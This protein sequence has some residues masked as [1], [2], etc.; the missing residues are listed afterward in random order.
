MASQ[1]WTPERLA[2][3]RNLW[4]EGETAAAIAV[5]LGGLSRS[6]VLGKVYRLRLD[7]AGSTAAAKPK[8]AGAR[9]G[10]A[11]LARRRQGGKRKLSPQ[12]PPTTGRRGKTLLE[13]TNATCRWPHGRPGTKNFFFCGEAGADLERGLPYC[14]RHMQRAYPAIES[15]AGRDKRPISGGGRL[16]LPSIR[17]R[18]AATAGCPHRL[19]NCEDGL[20]ARSRNS[21]RPRASEGADAERPLAEQAATAAHAELRGDRAGILGATGHNA[22]QPLLVRGRRV[23]ERWSFLH[24]IER[25]EE[26][27]RILARL[28]VATRPRGYVNSMPYYLYDRGDLNA[29]METYELERMARMRNRVRIAPSPAEVARMEEALRWPTLFLSGRVSARCPRRQSRLAVVGL[30]C[31][32]R[33]RPQADEDHPAHLQRAQAPGPAHHRPRARPPPHRRALI[34]GAVSAPANF[35]RYNTGDRPWIRETA[36][37]AAP[38]GARQR[39]ARC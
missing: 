19:T 38:P 30:R 32:H 29:Q 24:V 3:L 37:P 36:P 34:A 6:A 26:A 28:P 10:N 7:G 20:A 27:F 25:M 12:V 21:Q 39:S 22:P 17:Y 23:P 18:T 16:L 9:V 8:R 4:S 35:L 5:R 15:A 13:L 14:A 1:S 11:P 33:R 31:R 2:L